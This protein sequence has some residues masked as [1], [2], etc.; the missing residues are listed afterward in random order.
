MELP[1]KNWKRFENEYQKW[2]LT[3]RPFVIKI[4]WTVIT[5]GKSIVEK[6]FPFRSMLDL[7]DAEVN[8]AEE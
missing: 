5:V 4:Q 8:D 7:A 3:G 2:F 1:R 6:V